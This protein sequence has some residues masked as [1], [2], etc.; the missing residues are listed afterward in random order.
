MIFRFIHR[1]FAEP[2]PWD[3]FVGILASLPDNF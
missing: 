1:Y 3:A 2:A